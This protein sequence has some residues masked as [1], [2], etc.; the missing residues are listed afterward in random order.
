MRILYSSGFDEENRSHSMDSRYRKVLTR[1]V[2]KMF[3]KAWGVKARMQSP[4][5][6]DYSNDVSYSQSS[7]GSQ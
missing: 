7:P 3:G 4:M 1:G 5:I 2:H 6:S